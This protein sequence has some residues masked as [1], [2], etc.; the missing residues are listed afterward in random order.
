MNPLAAGDSLV[1][2]LVQHRTVYPIKH[3]VVKS[4]AKRV[5]SLTP[6]LAVKLS[7][8]PEKEQ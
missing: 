4:A 8:S 1:E 2:K 7:I 5:Q 3:R 6:A